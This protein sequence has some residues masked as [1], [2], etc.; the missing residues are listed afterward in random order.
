MPNSYDDIKKFGQELIQAREQRGMSLEQISDITKVHERYL[1]A[2]EEGHWDLLPRPYMESFL[3]AYAEAVGMNIPKVMQE[4]HDLMPGETRP[5]G[6]ERLE[7]ETPEEA[8][9]DRPPHRRSRTWYI[10]G[11]LVVLI[12]AAALIAYFAWKPDLQTL[13]VHQVQ[14]GRMI[15]PT[16]TLQPFHPD[17]AARADSL[18]PD[19]L[20]PDTTVID[21]GATLQV[22]AD[23][24]L[25][26]IAG[27]NL[28]A[29]AFQPCWLRATLDNAEVQEVLLQA[30]DSI[31]WKA[32]DEVMMVIGNAG[33]VHL[34]MDGED[35]GVLGP[36]GKV[37]TVVITPDGIQSQRMGKEKL[38][39]P[40]GPE[41]LPD[42]TRVNQASNT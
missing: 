31:A 5:P 12:V 29:R 22:P 19:T 40:M 26:N 41:S 36:E 35:L 28:V 16:D 38:T 32:S 9:A 37:V 14:G 21:T 10:L 23:P 27:M 39:P 7:P 4:F 3:H 24:R 42:T 17:S 25:S 1:R 2:M 30:G 15:A 11:G 8:A 6:R 20:R 13:P 33:G 18:L 34:E